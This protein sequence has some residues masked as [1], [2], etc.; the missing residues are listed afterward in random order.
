MPLPCDRILQ[1][2]RMVQY[3][4]GRSGCLWIKGR[5]GGAVS[6]SITFWWRISQL[7]AFHYCLPFPESIFR[8]HP[9]QTVSLPSPW[10]SNYIN[11]LCMYSIYKHIC[12]LYIR[13]W[14]ASSPNHQFSP[15]QYYTTLV[16]NSCCI[17]KSAQGTGWAFNIFAVPTVHLSKYSFIWNDI[18][19]LHKYLLSISYES[20]N[21]VGIERTQQNPISLEAC[22]S[23]AICVQI[24][25]FH[26]D[27]NQAMPTIKTVTRAHL[28]TCLL[29]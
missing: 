6:K 7:F 29:K 13:G 26:S 1:A 11:I 24:Q 19:I 3:V 21:V 25:L 16:E 15:I 28:E 5:E 27:Q 4:N 2:E 23:E 18:I 14:F 10:N 22:L 12:A 8:L 17:L 20:S 9:P